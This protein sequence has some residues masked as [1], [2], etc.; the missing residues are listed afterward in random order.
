[1]LFRL[2]LILCLSCSTFLLPFLLPLAG[3]IVLFPAL[4]F[5]IIPFSSVFF[6]FPSVD[7][8]IVYAPSLLQ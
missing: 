5:V 3:N 6:F 7:V 4:P 2:S 8:Q 1:M